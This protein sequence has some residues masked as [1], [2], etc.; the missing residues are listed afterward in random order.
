MLRVTSAWIQRSADR[1]QQLTGSEHIGDGEAAS[2]LARM[3]G[4]HMAG[5]GAHARLALLFPR[6]RVLR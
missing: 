2:G 4:G 6:M 3:H 5:P 1:P